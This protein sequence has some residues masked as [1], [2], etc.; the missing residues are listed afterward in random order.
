[1]KASSPAGA[2]EL[3]IQLIRQVMES[4]DPSAIVLQC[5]TNSLSG[6]T[7]GCLNLSMRGM[8]RS[9]AH[10]L[11]EYFFRA[12]QLRQICEVFQQASFT[13]WGRRVYDAQCKSS[14]GTYKTGLAADVE[15]TPGLSSV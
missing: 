9:F 14:I 12:C 3:A 6:D 11:S 15:L 8:T 10:N 2:Y 5:G 1:M 7:L 4:Y 13:P